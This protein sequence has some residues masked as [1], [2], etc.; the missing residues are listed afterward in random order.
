MGYF[1][2][3]NK[4]VTIIIKVAVLG[5]AERQALGMADYLIKKFNCKVT[6]VTSHSNI[7]T[8]EFRDFANKCGIYEIHFFGTPSLFITNEISIKSFKKRIRALLYI[9]KMKREVSKFKPDIII[10]FLNS[11]SKIAALIYKKTG[12]KTTFWHQLGL[13]SYLF[14]SLE[15]KAI[16]QTPFFIANAPDGL[17]T[18][19][20][21][22]KIDENKLYYL[23]QYVSL[24]KIEFDNLAIR[25]E[26]NIDENTLIIGMIAHYREEKFFELLMNAFSKLS[27]FYNIHLV[28]LGNK[29]NNEET[30]HIYNALKNQRKSLKLEN[31]VTILSGFQVEKVLSLINIGVLVSAIEG[32]PN[33]ILE[34]MLYGKAIIASDHE[35]CKKLLPNSDFLIPNDQE[36]L[37]TKLKILIE[38]EKLRKLESKKNEKNIK[39]FDIEGYFDSLLKIINKNLS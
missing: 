4:N 29:D 6:L 5:G 22:Y 15:N 19:N 10:P 32:T 26:L 16:N 8:I 1:E 25:K 28:F 30:L 36:I 27:D 34:Y 37:I 39:N 23:P 14:D 11:P 35:G 18:F 12:A 3:F 38:N 2:F 31:K 33:V 21:K 7:S 20:D 24:K 17:L 9:N 13:D